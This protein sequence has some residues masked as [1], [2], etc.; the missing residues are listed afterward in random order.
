MLT[1]ED[2]VAVIK[3][4]EAPI[5]EAVKGDEEARSW[6]RGVCRELMQRGTFGSK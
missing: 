4:V 5:V 6:I 3:S 1:D 2:A